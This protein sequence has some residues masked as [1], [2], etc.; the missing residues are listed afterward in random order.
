LDWTAPGRPAGLRSYS[1]YRGTAPEASKMKSIGRTKWAETYFLD[2]TV[3]PGQTYYY[4]VRSIKM[5]RGIPFESQ[6]SSVVEIHVPSRRVKSPES[7]VVASTRTGIRVHWDPVS[8]EDAETQYNVYRSEASRMFVKLNA[9]PLNGPRF[10]DK[11]VKR[12]YTYR[13]AVTAFP[14]GSP[15]DESG[16]SAS[17]AIKYNR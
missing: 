8:I 14:K 4:V 9:G 11:T 13:Y 7:I 17:E 16:R 3:E 10:V 2:E 1:I 6:S 5:N 12:G 15:E